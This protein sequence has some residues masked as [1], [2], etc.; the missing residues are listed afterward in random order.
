MIALSKLSNFPH[1]LSESDE[2]R[3]YELSG[4]DCNALF[5]FSERRIAAQLF[6]VCGK[7]CRIATM[8]YSRSITVSLFE[9]NLPFK[10]LSVS[11]KDK[12]ISVAFQYDIR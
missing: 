9:N 6:C 12:G 7:L 3:E 1:E 2:L 8:P 10:I 4:S 11:A 5:R